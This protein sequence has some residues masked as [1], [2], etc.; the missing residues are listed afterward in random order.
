MANRRMNKLAQKK[1]L[2]HTQSTLDATPEKPLA[3]KKVEVA[4]LNLKPK[5]IMSKTKPD[6]P[7]KPMI[8]EHIVRSPTKKDRSSLIGMKRTRKSRDQIYELTRI[9]DEAHGKPTKEQLE[10]LAVDTGLKL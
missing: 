7:M 10:K 9:Y 4:P 2:V 3:G 5:R 1:E 6:S 8:I